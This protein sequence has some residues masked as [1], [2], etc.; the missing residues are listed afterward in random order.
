MLPNSSLLRT[1]CEILC[2]IRFWPPIPTLLTD[3][4]TAFSC[5]HFWGFQAVLHQCSFAVHQ[6]WGGHFLIKKR[7]PALAE[8]YAPWLCGEGPGDWVRLRLRLVR[9]VCFW[10]KPREYRNMY[11]TVYIIIHLYTALHCT[12]QSISC[13]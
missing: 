10:K 3:L 7:H 1:F 11:C 2:R 6:G 5:I 4:C 12:T 9:L 13:F 8:V